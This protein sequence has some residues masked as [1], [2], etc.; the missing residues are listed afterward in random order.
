VAIPAQ[1]AALQ[2]RGF[3]L[4]MNLVTD[5]FKPAKSVIIISKSFGVGNTHLSA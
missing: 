3:R 4:E 1:N 5:D 2:S